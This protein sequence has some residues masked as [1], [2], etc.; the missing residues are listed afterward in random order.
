MVPNKYFGPAFH[1]GDEVVRILGNYRGN[2]GTFVGLREDA[3]WADITD[4]DG[5]VRSCPVSWLA[6]V[7]KF[8]RTISANSKTSEE[9]YK[10]PD[11]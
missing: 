4:S 5:F 1:E 2:P 6:H 8:P 11:A 7:C 10:E 9:P 3:N